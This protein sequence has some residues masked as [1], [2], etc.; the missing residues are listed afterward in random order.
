MNFFS[1][2]AGQERRRRLDAAIAGAGEMARYYMGPGFS[3]TGR[4]V[5][6]IASYVNP[7]NDIGDAMSAGRDGRWADMAVSTATAAAPVVAGKVAKAMNPRMVDDVAEFLEDALLGMSVNPM[8]AS[9]KAAP[10]QFVADE[11]GNVPLASK[12]L[13]PSQQQAQDVLDLLTTGRADEVTDD[14]L[15][16]AD[17]YYLYQN[18]DLPMDEASRMARA[19]EMGFDAGTPLFHGTLTPHDR[20]RPIDDVY[21]RYER[22]GTYGGDG[23][24]GPGYY[25]TTSSR[26]ASLNYADAT[27]PDVRNK[28]DTQYE[29]IWEMDFDEL[30]DELRLSLDPE[31]LRT[32]DPEAA[33][34]LREVNEKDQSSLTAGDTEAW[35][36]YLA[37]ATT[38]E[39]MAQVA[40][41]RA[42]GKTDGAV[43]PVLGRANNPVK[44]KN[45]N[46]T[47]FEMQPDIPDYTEFLD[48]AGG[49]EDL[50]LDLALDAGFERDPQ[51]PLVDFAASVHNQ[52]SDVGLDE[53]AWE[54]QGDL[55]QRGYDYGGLSAADLEH[56][57]RNS[58]AMEYA[59]DYDLSPGAVLNRAYRDAGYDA[60]D[61]HNPQTTFSAM[62]NMEDTAFHRVFT[63]PNALR[64][65]FA[66]FDPRLKHLTNL[67]AGV[68]GAAYLTADEN[69]ELRAYLGVE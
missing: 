28:I 60:I 48:E 9:L 41:R 58:R 13:S 53:Q 50:A 15:A 62:P 65:R 69:A 49:D 47:L 24:H 5:L 17:D 56:V 40:A 43:I 66:R 67:S 32:V 14:M 46:S 3:D 19:K 12:K 33:R 64:S 39:D 7:V 8:S 44:T 61:L 1:H 20:V 31:D 11:A 16:A 18:Y 54:L 51:G 37:N 25:T 36:N 55:I 63:K 68:G 59:V 23:H 34:L 21:D 22:T 27:G 42:V 35:E 2:E 38:L 4:N 26:D 57:V 30:A 29:R 6:G 10:G 52:L 45:P